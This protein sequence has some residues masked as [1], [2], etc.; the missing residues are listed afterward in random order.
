MENNPT[1]SVVMPA[2]AQVKYIEDAI[3]SILNQSWA[4]FELLVINDRL[5]QDAVT[6]I[7][8]ISSSDQRVKFYKSD[9][10]GI[11]EA[12]NKGI[13]LSKG[14]YIARMDSDD[15]SEKFRLE[16]QVL[17]MQSHPEVGI[18]GTQIN[19]ISQDGKQ[20][21]QSRFPTSHKKIAKEL[22]FYNCIAHPTVMIRKSVID[23]IGQY[24]SKYDG[25]EDYELWIRAIEKTSIRNLGTPLLQYRESD[26][27][28]TKS[29]SR[30]IDRQEKSILWSRLLSD[31]SNESSPKIMKSRI[32][33]TDSTLLIRSVY[34]S[35]DRNFLLKD[36]VKKVL[37]REI[38]I[39]RKTIFTT[40]EIISRRLFIRITRGIG[41]K[42]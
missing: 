27:Q 9:G 10:A 3:Q 31:L 33:Q 15:I 38:S 21:G 40:F 22:S 41:G 2:H 19:Y 26:S 12:L 16:H 1:I 7:E 23:I 18:L 24:D 13:S 32:D 17:F 30:I 29:N 28:V 6:R 8:R 42:K 25:S 4:D 20:T 37:K 14:K 34:H 39:S 5:S 11:S 35:K 36:L